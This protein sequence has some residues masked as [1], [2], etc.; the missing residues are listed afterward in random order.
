MLSTLFA[1]GF[2]NLQDR[3]G[4]LNSSE[5]TSLFETSPGNPWS[6]QG[7]P[8]TTTSDESGAVTLQGWLAQWSMTTLLEHKTT[9]A[10]L[11]YLGYPDSDTTTAL[12]VTR[13]RRLDR[14][15]KSISTPKGKG[16]NANRNV[17]LC[18]VCGAAGSGKTALL[19]SFVRRGYRDA[20]IPTTKGMSVVNSVEIDGSEKYLVVCLE[21]QKRH[22]ADT[23][24]RCRS[25][26]Q[27]PKLTC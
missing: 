10:H 25:S 20:Y 16:K 7:F 19:R 6:G 2:D 4:A 13:P 14:R 5:L 26:G 22:A 8:D 27:N 18:W 15:G 17:F 12:R 1:T 24:D 21:I 3:D 9:L 23:D 11:A